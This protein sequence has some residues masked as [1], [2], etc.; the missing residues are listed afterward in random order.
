M[1]ALQWPSK[2]R[3]VLGARPLAPFLPLSLSTPLPLKVEFACP[4]SGARMLASAVASAL[5]SVLLVVSD[6]QAAKSSVTCSTRLKCTILFSLASNLINLVPSSGLR[7][8]KII[9]THARSGRRSETS[10]TR[11]AHQMSLLCLRKYHPS[12]IHWKWI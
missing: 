6:V 1:H 11:P 3:R 4:L 8:T 2:A 9:V 10:V 7:K 12:S 5:V